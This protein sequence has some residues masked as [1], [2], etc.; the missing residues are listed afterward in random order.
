[1]TIGGV[2]Q[3]VLMS[4]SGATSVGLA[5]GKQLWQ[6]PLEAGPRIVQP[7]LTAE[8]DLLMTVGGEGMG[9]E[10]VRRIA[11]AHGPEGW[12]AQERWT[13]RA[14]KP[15]F[16]DFVVHKGHAFGFDGSILSCIDLQD[17]QRKWK[18]G[19]YGNGQ[20]VLLADE[21]LLLVLSEEG[22]LA[23]VKATPDQFREIARF[24]AITGKTW[25]H[26]ALAGDVLLVRN[27]EEMAAFRL[28]LTGRADD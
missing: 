25:N 21:D 16:N 24:P 9:G 27:G 17:G 28:S 2:S 18:G 1:M 23:L 7:A 12:S 26:P 10:G 3:V 11:V 19:R 15:N 20:L 22:E 4:G 6:H 13:S 14:L 8:G 5:D